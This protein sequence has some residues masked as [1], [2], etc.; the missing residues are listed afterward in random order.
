MRLKKDKIWNAVS[1]SSTLNE[2]QVNTL[3]PIFIKSQIPENIKSE[4]QVIERLLLCSYFE[5][6]FIDLAFSQTMFTLEKSI[7]IKYN[8]VNNELSKKLRFAELIEWCFENNYFETNN[9]EELKGLRNLRNR[10]VHEEKSLLGGF[11]FLNKIYSVFNLINDLYEDPI[12]RVDRKKE[13]EKLQIEL[14]AFLKEGGIISYGGKRI[15]IFKVD[16]VFLDN[17]SLPN[18]LTVSISPIFDLENIENSSFV[19]FGTFQIELKDWQFE[20]SL[21][22]GID[23]SKNTIVS[24]SKINENDINRG[25]FVEWK[26]KFE[27]LDNYL[28]LSFMTYHIDYN[29]YHTAISKFYASKDYCK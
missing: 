19:N 10:K 8:E 15:I 28:L 25:K 18:V 21:F 11:A 22:K 7:R 20:N 27:S 5:F 17:K 26:N 24:I 29:I 1:H 2:F 12:L 4:I 13:I 9:K 14:N 23:G 3:K 6:K 16:V